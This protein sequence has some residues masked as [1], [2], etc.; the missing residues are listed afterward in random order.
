MA[1][2]LSSTS[3]SP[4]STQSPPNQLLVQHHA[5]HELRENCS[6]CSSIHDRIC[7]P[8]HPLSPLPALW[9]PFHS[10]CRCLSPSVQYSVVGAGVAHGAREATH[11]PPPMSSPSGWTATSMPP[12]TTASALGVG[13]DIATTPS[14]WM[15]VR[16]SIPQLPP[17]STCSSPLS[18]LFPPC[19]PPPPL[20]LRLLLASVDRRGVNRGARRGRGGREGGGGGRREGGGGRG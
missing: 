15:D 16:G 7:S 17:H 13:T 2:L 11:F 10:F 8:T 3:P 5:Q 20:P 12:P 14:G 9:T 18:P 6:D 1:Q 4:I 19:P